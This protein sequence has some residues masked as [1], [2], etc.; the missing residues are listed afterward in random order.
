MKP[1]LFLQNRRSVTF[2]EITVKGI[3][4]YLP[5]YDEL[6]CAGETRIIIHGGCFL[7]RLVTVADAATPLFIL[8]G[9]W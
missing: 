8:I 4:D 3:S 9:P 7:A 2:L 1:K 6:L 5:T